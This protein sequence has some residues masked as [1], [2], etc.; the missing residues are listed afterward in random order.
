MVA[1]WIAALFWMLGLF[2]APAFAFDDPP[3]E[4][5]KQVTVLTGD[6][7]AEDWRSGSIKL[8][9]KMYTWQ[10]D[11]HL[12]I[13][14][15]EPVAGRTA[16]AVVKGHF[17]GDSLG[18]DST[19]PTLIRM[20]DA[21]EIGP[22]ILLKSY[23]WEHAFDDNTSFYGIITTSR[24]SYIPFFANCERQD[25]KYPDQY[26]FEPCVR[27]ITKLLVILQGGPAAEGKTLTMP[28]PPS[29]LS[30]AG[31]DGQYLKNGMSLATNGSRNGLRKVLLYASPPMDIPADKIAPALRQFSDSIIHDDDDADENP[32]SIKVVG[33]NADPWLR[34]EFP[35]AFEGPSI[36]MAGIE[37]TPDRKIVFVGIR[38][39]NSGWLKTCAYGVEQARTQIKTGQLQ[40]RRSA[41]IAARQSP[42]LPNGIKDAQVLGIYGTAEFNGNSFVINGNLYLK[43]GTVY[44]SISKVPAM[45]DAA[46]SRRESPADWGRWRRAGNVIHITWGDGDT[47]TASASPD[48]LFVGGTRATKLSGFY[49]TVSSGSTGMGGGWVSR[50]SYT[51]FPDGT[52][53][54]DRSSS[55][56]VGGFVPGEVGPTQI[57]AGGSSSGTGKARYEIDGYMI[58]FFYPDGQIEREAFAMY[59]ADV[60]NPKR[61]YILI[62]GTPFT[63]NNGD[64]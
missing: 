45:I 57:A 55:F 13:M 53:E 58:S 61:K 42:I 19:D 39:P 28:P 17:D 2:A 30:I 48:E 4:F 21:K 11:I 60:N 56:S 36:Q 44:N 31:W 9:P 5:S 24:N 46:A 34:R 26:Q 29:P 33:T 64:D 15:E 18:D 63:L 3:T 1:R 20:A 41:Y 22:G 23:R 16:L 32:G 50:E 38:C 49:G 7:E 37:Y 12:T 14:S 8:H 43:D 27:T 52:F 35:E 25:P 59:S 47:D 10:S 62:G 6:W 54:N 51:F 40:A